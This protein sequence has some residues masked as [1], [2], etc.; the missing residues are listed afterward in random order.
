MFKKLLILFLSSFL[1]FSCSK[2]K[3]TEGIAVEQSQEEIGKTLYEEGVVALIDGDAFYAA[4]KFKEA[5]SLLSQYT[6]ASKASLLASYADYS[7]SSY[8]SAI[9]SLERHINNYPA[10][11]NITYAHYLM[12]MCYYEQILDEKKDI[13]PLVETKK[14]IKFYLKNFPILD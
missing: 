14:K 6:W 3:N 12:A 8:A 11:K 9:L 5:E 1:L 7:R 4:K 2:G 13:G 10:D